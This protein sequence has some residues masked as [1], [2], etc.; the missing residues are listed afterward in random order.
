M[1]SKETKQNVEVLVALIGAVATI[2]AGLLGSPLIEKWL[3]SSSEPTPTALQLSLATDTPT[4]TSIFIPSVPVE[5]LAP[6]L[7]PYPE[8]ILNVD[9]AGNKILMRLVPAGEFAMG[10][11]NG[12]DDEKPI[13]MVYLDAFYMDKY[14]VTN[15][16]YKACVDAGACE[17]PRESRSLHRY[18]YYGNVEYNN[19]PVVYV[20]WYQAKAYCE[21]RGV[22][23]P[24]EAQWEKAA[25]GT[26]ERIY[27]WGR[28]RISCNKA[29]Y[30][31]ACV[32]DTSKVGIYESGKSPYEIYDLK[33]NVWEWVDAWY[34]AYPGNVI[35]NS[36]YGTIYKVLRGGS[37][38][39]LE[40]DAPVTY[41]SGGSPDYNYAD[42][43]FRCVRSP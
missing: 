41:R 29:N 3:D 8:E 6:S 4:F 1:S 7:Y 22:A 39:Y 36:S 17:A 15:A 33:G 19:Y 24:T 43:G 11:E 38:S 16:L 2:I 42:V 9:P 37:Y 31:N 35:P 25:R 34:D 21:W 20:D 18:D 13:H 26:D 28:E 30:T 10:S 14:E 12:E 27:P 40:G 5:T 23:L 32:G